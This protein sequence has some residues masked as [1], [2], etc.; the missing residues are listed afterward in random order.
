MATN[1]SIVTDTEIQQF[2]DSIIEWKK[3]RKEIEMAQEAGLDTPLTV[4]DIDTKINATI[5]IIE[6]YTGQ[7]YNP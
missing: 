3:L 7:R 5:K 2:K 4:K 1:S 6:A